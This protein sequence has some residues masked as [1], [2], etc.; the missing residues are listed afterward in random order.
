MVIGAVIQARMNSLRLPGK[1]LQVIHGKPLLQYVL[2]RVK[3]SKK[4]DEIAIATSNEPSDYPIYEFCQNQNVECFRGSLYDVAGRFNQILHMK[5]WDAFVRVNGDSPLLDQQLID[6]GVQIYNSGDYDLVTNVFP[7]SYPRGQSVEVIRAGR[8][9]EL[10][11]KMKCDLEK[12]HVTRYYYD[13][14]SDV[15]IYNFSSLI[16]YSHIQLSVDT[17]EDLNQFS[18][19]I[20]KMPGKHWDYHLEDIIRIYNQI[21]Q[22]SGAL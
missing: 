21:Q 19:I 9:Q 22:I 11:P 15:T 12:E 13:H 18:Q 10:N 20:S 14:P 7:R 4:V 17:R 16:D 5:K 1:V 2:E 6:T 3:C 8:F